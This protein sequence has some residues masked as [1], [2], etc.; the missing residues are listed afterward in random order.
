MINSV[1]LA[2][3]LS[4]LR[5]A[6]KETYSRG[7]IILG[8]SPVFPLSKKFPKIREILVVFDQFG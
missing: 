3:G 5:I 2:T 8:D 7:P 6:E 1:P 4:E